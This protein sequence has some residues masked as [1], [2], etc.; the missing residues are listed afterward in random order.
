MQGAANQGEHRMAELQLGN[1]H[2]C[3]KC[4]AK[5]YDFGKAAPLTCP[6]CKHSFSPKLPHAVAAPT[7]PQISKSKP[8]P[9]PKAA[10]VIEEEEEDMEEMGGIEPLEDFDDEY[11][12]DVVSLEEVEDHHEDPE[13]DRN[14]DD[15]DDEMF[16]EDLQ[17]HEK[18]VDSLSDYREELELD[19]EEE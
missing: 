18:L 2:V 19:G 5:F 13:V 7:V 14:S 10:P 8:K 3:P 9:K 4:G 12:E 6:K 17:D 15:A 11:D 16:M 1:K